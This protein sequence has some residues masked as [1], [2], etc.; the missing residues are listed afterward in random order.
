[1]CVRK[2]FQQ[3]KCIPQLLIYESSDDEQI[4]MHQPKS[5][6]EIY[7][8]FITQS[9]YHKEFLAAQVCKINHMESVCEWESNSNVEIIVDLQWINTQHL[10]FNYLE[11]NSNRKQCE[12]R[13]F[14]Y[15][16]ILKIS[17]SML[18]TKDFTMFRHRHS[19][20]SVMRT[21]MFCPGH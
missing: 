4:V 15:T 17:A 2:L 3:L 16:H 1:M 5:L 14:D 10:I 7:R 12:M 21:M 19:L 11:W 8:K 18:A 13:T 20:T 6:F 9:K